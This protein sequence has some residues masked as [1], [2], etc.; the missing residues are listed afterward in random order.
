MSAGSRSAR[1]ARALTSRRD[2]KGLL[3]VR[4]RLVRSARPAAARASPPTHTRSAPAIRLRESRC[5]RPANNAA[6]SA[7]EMLREAV[8][9]RCRSQP[10]RR[11]PSASA[12]SSTRTPCGSR[13]SDTVILLPFERE[14]RPRPSDRAASHGH[15]PC[16]SASLACSSRSRSAASA[17][18]RGACTGSSVRPAATSCAMARARARRKTGRVR[19]SAV[20]SARTRASAVS[21]AL[22]QRCDQRRVA[23]EEGRH[24]EP[25]GVADAEP[26]AQRRRQ[27]ARRDLAHAAGP[28]AR[29]DRP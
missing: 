17:A 21:R 28:C 27:R 19:R 18:M 26:P 16:S 23:D 14:A 29:R 6:R 12:R 9:R 20:A 5:E 15:G 2:G 10:L 24:A 4:A 7:S 8:R 13:R 3:Q 11:R 22:I 25:G 1:P